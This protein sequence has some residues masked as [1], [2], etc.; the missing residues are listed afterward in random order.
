MISSRSLD[1][2]HPTVKDMAEKFLAKCKNENIDILITCTYR[3]NAMQD[4]LYARGRTLLWEHGQKVKKVTNAQGGQSMH[5]YHLAFDM[6]P[7]R[8]GKPVWSTTGA[9]LMLYMRVGDIGESLGLEWA[10][11][12]VSMKEMAHFQFTGGHPLSYFQNGGKL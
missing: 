6:V 9:D 5:N 12:W 2:L 7:L 3:D 10:G 11:R 1:D 4:S 8:D